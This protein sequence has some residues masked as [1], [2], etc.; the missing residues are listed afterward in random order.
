VDDLPVL[1]RAGNLRQRIGDESGDAVCALAAAEDDEQRAA[2]QNWF[3]C[4]ARGDDS[5][6]GVAAGTTDTDSTAFI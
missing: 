3:A 2:S 1:Q 4:W 5:V 6:N